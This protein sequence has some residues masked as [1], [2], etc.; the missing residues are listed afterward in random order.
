M[1][2]KKYFYQLVI[3]I[4]INSVNAQSKL[5]TGLITDIEKRPIENANLKIQNSPE[6]AV[7]DK[8]GKYELRDFSDGEYTLIVSSVGYK[9][10]SKSVSVSEGET[11][12]INFILQKKILKLK[13]LLLQE[14]AQ[15]KINIIPP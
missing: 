4:A 2:S 7:S 10:Q 8:E 6:G 12:Q 3:V 1:F 5:I 14:P 15:K 11:T 9:T 13:I